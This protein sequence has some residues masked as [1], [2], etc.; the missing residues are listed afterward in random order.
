MPGQR[1]TATRVRDSPLHVR[2]HPAAVRLTHA[3]SDQRLRH[4]PCRRV[5]CA[6]PQ[7]GLA[8]HLLRHPV[9]FLLMMITG[10]AEQ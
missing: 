4:V 3:M 8:R 1:A 5:A 10:R 2:V 7:P 6:R 9:G